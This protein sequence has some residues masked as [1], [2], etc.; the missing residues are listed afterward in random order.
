[1]KFVG[2]LV[3]TL[4]RIFFLVVSIVS[5]AFGAY[6]VAVFFTKSETFTTFITNHPNWFFNWVIGS[7]TVGA[8][9]IHYSDRAAN[10]LVFP[11]VLVFIGTVAWVTQ[12]SLKNR[13]IYR[14]IRFRHPNQASPIAWLLVLA[15]TAASIYVLANWNSV[16]HTIGIIVIAANVSSILWNLSL[17]R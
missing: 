5:G 7:T 9:I 4:F 13:T 3:K 8:T 10:G 14:R 16:D 15:A 2:S 17:F 12:V 11:V 1:M 6:G